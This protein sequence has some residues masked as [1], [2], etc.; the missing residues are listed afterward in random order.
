MF[1]PARQ[2]ISGLRWEEGDVSYSL[3]GRSLTC[4]EAVG[5]FLSLRPID[6]L[7]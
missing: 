1:Q 6:E 4:E 3:T 2:G 5:L 7:S